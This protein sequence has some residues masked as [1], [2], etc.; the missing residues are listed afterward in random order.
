[1]VGISVNLGYCMGAIF[2]LN[3]AVMHNHFSPESCRLFPQT[4]SPRILY[5]SYQLTT[6]PITANY[7]ELYDRLLASYQC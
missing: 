5:I 1:M 6:T 3:R 7:L 2:A 4:H